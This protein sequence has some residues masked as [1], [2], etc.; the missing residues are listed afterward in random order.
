MIKKKSLL[1]V[2]LLAVAYVCM[3]FGSISFAS[4]DAAAA[5]D[6]YDS[7]GFS[8]SDLSADWALS[9]GV[10]GVAEDCADEVV[11]ASNVDIWGNQ[12]LVPTQL[13]TAP[14]TIE[15]TV[16]LP[17]GDSY[18]WLNVAPAGTALTNSNALVFANQWGGYV[19]H[20][21]G[22]L[23]VEGNLAGYNGEND[24]M[25]VTV[26]ESG[27]ITPYLNGAAYTP[28]PGLPAGLW[29]N[30]VKD[31]QIGICFHGAVTTVLKEFKVTEGLDGTGKVLFYDTFETKNFGAGMQKWSG[32]NMNEGLN[33]AQMMQW[34]A[35]NALTFSAAEEALAAN[36]TQWAIDSTGSRNVF[37]FAFSSAL[38]GENKLG[39]VFGMKD[40]ASGIDQNAS[41][42]YISDTQIAVEGTGAAAVNLPAGFAFSEQSNIIEI[43]NYR[44]GDVNIA[45]VFAI[46]RTFANNTVTESRTKLASFSGM[47][48]GGYWGFT[49]KDAKV[50]EV[51]LES[52]PFEAT[53]PPV[54]DVSE[55]PTRAYVGDTLDLTPKAQDTIDG[56]VAASV[57]IKDYKGNVVGSEMNFAPA[58]PGWYTV[59]YTAKNSFGIEATAEV[60]V[61]F[62]AKDTMGS[63]TDN[64][65]GSLG[66]SYTAANAAVKDGAAVLQ[67]GSSAASLERNGVVK[68]FILT[69]DITSNTLADSFTVVFGKIEQDVYHGVQFTKGGEVK[70]VGFDEESTAELSRDLWK[71]NGKFTMRITVSGGKVSIAVIEQ[72]EPLN[73]LNEP[74]ITFDG[75]VHA[76]AVGWLTQSASGELAVDNVRLVN[77]GAYSEIDDEDEPKVPVDSDP[78][79]PESPEEPSGGCSGSVGGIQI[80]VAAAALIGVAAV[81]LKTKK[82]KE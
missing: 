7:Y 72:G 3:A 47:A 15:M 38:S 60:R 32:T 78:E 36:K 1:T 74:E 50:F 43:Q 63:F 23:P 48:F 59:K 5:Q 14:Y 81:A 56:A 80:A 21:T 29:A 37:R 28:A 40:S 24:V 67:G 79:D 25:K 34:P 45:N 30:G 4:A 8:K 11:N 64:F 2:F 53:Q 66:E 75:V 27:N 71:Q 35:E 31:A 41:V 52:G 16:D 9:N 82:R 20:W 76:G 42:M 46:T 54:I 13:F 22:A 26:D 19:G 58:K 10:S 65:D 69:F 77:T 57:E 39:V 62:V 55:V 61:L 70:T 51:E 33:G 44:Q 12:F 49:A 68:N 17:E 18:T 6:T 73:I